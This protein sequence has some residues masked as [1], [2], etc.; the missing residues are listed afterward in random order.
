MS[1]RRSSL[2]VAVLTLGLQKHA[3]GLALL[4]EIEDKAGSSQQRGRTPHPSRYKATQLALS[5]LSAAANDYKL[6]GLSRGTKTR[7]LDAILAAHAGR[8]ATNAGPDSLG[9]AHDAD[10]AVAGQDGGGGQL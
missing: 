1:D 10:R 6:V 9:P 8:Q 5:F 3:V 2:R 7:S 4:A